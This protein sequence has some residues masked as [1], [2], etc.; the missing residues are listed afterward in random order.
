MIAM[1][2]ISQ[3][4]TIKKNIYDYVKNATVGIEFISQYSPY[5]GNVQREGIATSFVINKEKGWILTN[6][7]VVN[8]Y[9]IQERFVKFYNGAK[10]RASLIYDDLQHDFAI[11][12]VN[13]L[14]IPK[15]TNQIKLSSE[16]IKV[17]QEVFMI[18]FNDGLNFAFQD[19]KITQ[20]DTI[21]GLFA[22]QTLIISLNSQGGSSGSAV[23]NDK[24]EAIALNSAGDQIS[25]LAISINYIIE[26]IIEI[27]NGIQP[28]SKTFG[29]TFKSCDLDD[30]V[31]F[32]NFPESEEILYRE[33][34]P[35]ARNNAICIDKI[36]PN[37][38]ADGKFTLDDIIWKVNNKFI[39]NQIYQ[40][41]AAINQAN[42]EMNIEVYRDG[43]LIN[44]NIKPYEMQDNAIKKWLHMVGSFSMKQ[45]NILF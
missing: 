20:T 11:I 43:E 42:E 36:I 34:F 35:D 14:L 30:M 21:S 2:Y 8:R 4:E 32:A 41:S 13:P 15:Y 39:T 18:G 16:D 25:A 28:T 40:L 19:G 37:T 33:N 1:V 3:L 38:P 27:E 29:A 44:L 5:S 17:Q 23:C 10:L 24:G 45:T 12:K 6:N 31:K 9:D 7:H 26:K 22:T